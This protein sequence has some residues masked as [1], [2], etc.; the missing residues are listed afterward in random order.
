MEILGW[1]QNWFKDHC[2]GDWEHNFGIQIT[3]IDNPGWDVEIDISNTSI[4]NIHVPWILNEKNTQDWYGVK[5]E[6]QKFNAAGDPEKLT[7]LLELF[8]E[9]IEKIE[10]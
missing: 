4:A 6:N 8:K 5:I 1:I 3:T 10:K 7:F 9:M 2:D